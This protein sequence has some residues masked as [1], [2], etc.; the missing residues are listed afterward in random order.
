[1]WSPEHENCRNLNPHTSKIGKLL[2]V[3]ATNNRRQ[4]DHT[5]EPCA[6]FGENRQRIVDVIRNQ[7][8]IRNLRISKIRFLSPVPFT[9]EYNVGIAEFYLYMGFCSDLLK[10]VLKTAEIGIRTPL[11]SASYFRFV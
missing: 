11:K 5:S 3:C 6:K 1:M 8:Q 4:C 7:N 10:N 9:I 2:P